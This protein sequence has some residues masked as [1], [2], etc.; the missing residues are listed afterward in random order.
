MKNN[1]EVKGLLKKNPGMYS[2]GKNLMIRVGKKKHTWYARITVNGDRTDVPIGDYYSVRL[3]AAREKVAELQD[4][5]S[6]GDVIKA[7]K[8]FDDIVEMLKEISLSKSYVSAYN[9]HLKVDFGDRDIDSITSIDIQR[10]L[11]QML[12]SGLKTTP[13][14][15]LTVI[16]RVYKLALKLGLTKYNPAYTFESRDAGNHRSVSQRC[17]TMDELAEVF[18]CLRLLRLQ[19]RR[20]YLML[21]VKATL[22][23]RVRELVAM[24]KDDINFEQKWWITPTFLRGSNK[25]IHAAIPLEP[26]VIKWIKEAC[27]LS[28][29]SEYVFSDGIDPVDEKVLR[30][31]IVTQYESKRMSHI[32]YWSPHDL[33]RT[34]RTYMSQNGIA[35]N[36]AEAC[37]GHVKKGIEGVYNLDDHFEER[38]KAQRLYLDKIYRFIEPTI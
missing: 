9:T 35:D 7:Q 15:A 22:T 3:S 34:G 18:Q 19:N 30:R 33:R 28:P 1:Q 17:L 27:S 5:S 16:K 6:D 37:L 4:R 13:K 24:K 38:R 31:W 32:P 36:V 23:L 10:K 20:N 26:E 2:C 29:E 14:K 25:F 21:A 11:N 8:T 12:Q